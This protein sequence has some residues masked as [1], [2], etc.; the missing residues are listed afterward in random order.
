MYAN[1]DSSLYSFMQV[2]IP[3]GEDFRD[4]RGSI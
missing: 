1:K 4:N 3:F 2:A